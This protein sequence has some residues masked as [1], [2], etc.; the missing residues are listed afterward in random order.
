MD[1]T[2][3]QQDRPDI[4]ERTECVVR[5]AAGGARY[6]APPVVLAATHE[7]ALAVVPLAVLIRHA[8]VPDLERRWGWKTTQQSA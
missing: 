1:R 4:A 8:V 7:E 2:E 5:Q 3:L 6:L